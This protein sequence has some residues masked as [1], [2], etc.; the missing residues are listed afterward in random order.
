[1]PIPACNPDLIDAA[2]LVLPCAAFDAT[3]DFFTA[4][5]GLHECWRRFKPNLNRQARLSTAT[6]P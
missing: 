1:M 3:L 4:T 2:E 6:L 5:L